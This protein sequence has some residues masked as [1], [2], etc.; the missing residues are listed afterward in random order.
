MVK[1]RM[2]GRD[3]RAV[4]QTE[5]HPG[6]PSTAARP[7]AAV[8]LYVVLTLVAAAICALVA[9]GMPHGTPRELQLSGLIAFIAL[10]TVTDLR[11]VRL[12]VIGHV[13]L[14][15]VPVLAALIV[16]GLWPAI[17]VAAA[18]GVATVAVTRDPQKVAFNVGD[19][20]V[21]TFIAGLVYL[22]FVPAHPA[23]RADRAARLR[24]HRRRLRRQHRG[25][26]RR[27]RSGERQPPRGESGARTTS[28]ACRAT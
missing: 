25:A 11:E 10:S 7:R 8:A 17:V 26:R 21:S 27:H 6:R 2:V 16:F 3:R 23:L 12:P 20:V 1:I 14:S 19:Y 5:T 28:G 24:R 13:T 18:S 22:A 9:Y 4:T 15:F